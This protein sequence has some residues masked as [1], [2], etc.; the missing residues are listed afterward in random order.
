MFARSPLLEPH[1]KKVSGP[2]VVIWQNQIGGD[3]ISKLVQV[4]K[5]YVKIGVVKKGKRR[6]KEGRECNNREK[7]LTSLERNAT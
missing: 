5:E 3:F 6:K 7:I 1:N 4:W 2:L